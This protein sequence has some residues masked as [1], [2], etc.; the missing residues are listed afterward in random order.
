MENEPLTLQML[1]KIL[2]DKLLDGIY[3]LATDT[4]HHE[5]YIRFY[6][7]DELIITGDNLKMVFATGDDQTRI[8]TTEVQL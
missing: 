7:G 3:F 6:G 8:E 2:R 1:E 5:I 4:I